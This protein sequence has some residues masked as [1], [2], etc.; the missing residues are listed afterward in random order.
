MNKIEIHSVIN[1]P[2][3]EVYAILCN[4]EKAGKGGSGA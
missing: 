3:G 4:S 2:V 1:R